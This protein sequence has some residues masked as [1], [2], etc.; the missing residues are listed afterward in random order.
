MPLTQIYFRYSLS[1]SVTDLWMGYSNYAD[2]GVDNWVS[3]SLIVTPNIS[4]YFSKS[5]NLSDRTKNFALS[6]LKIAPIPGDYINWINVDIKTT[7]NY[8][9]KRSPN[10]NFE[11]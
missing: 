1:V 5:A 4:L 6:S 8:I 3:N 11:L 7:A 9:C 2:G 10:S